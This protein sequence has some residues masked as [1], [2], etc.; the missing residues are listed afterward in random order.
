MFKIQVY[1]FLN[2]VIIYNLFEI[3]VYMYMCINF[4]KILD[5]NYSYIFV[6]QNVLRIG[7]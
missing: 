4:I 2:M 3:G 1:C 7:D 6:Y 5:L